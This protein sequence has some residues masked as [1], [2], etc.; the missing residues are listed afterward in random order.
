MNSQVWEFKRLPMNVQ[1]RL[2]KQGCSLFNG[3]IRNFMSFVLRKKNPNDNQPKNSKQK[4]QKS[5]EMSLKRAWKPLYFCDPSTACSSAFMK[6]LSIYHTL[7]SFC[8]SLLSLIVHKSVSKS[9]MAMGSRM[10]CF[11]SQC[12]SFSL[13]CIENV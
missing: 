5:P 10:V 1:T 13:H 8:A 7:Q 3:C 2:E 12:T 4:H 11:H 6:T 9:I